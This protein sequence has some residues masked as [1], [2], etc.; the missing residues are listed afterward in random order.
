[1][2]DSCKD[3]H[4][5]QNLPVQHGSQSGGLIQM[6]KHMQLPKPYLTLEQ[7]HE[8]LLRRYNDG[9]LVLESEAFDCLFRLLLI[10]SELRTW[11][12]MERRSRLEPWIQEAGQIT[13]TKYVRPHRVFFF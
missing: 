10:S 7:E 11:S 4:V 12:S 8:F 5:R 2:I 9:L 13:L 6:I 1:M 3:Q